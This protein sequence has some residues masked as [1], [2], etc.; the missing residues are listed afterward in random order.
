MFPLQA[1]LAIPLNMIATTSLLEHPQREDLRC[2]LT[3]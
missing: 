2:F 1:T 3:K